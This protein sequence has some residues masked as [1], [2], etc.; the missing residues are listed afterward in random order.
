MHVQCTYVCIHMHIH[1]HVY[2]F[3]MYLSW[4]SSPVGW[5]EGEVE[6]FGDT[7]S[8]RLDSINIPV[9]RD[10]SNVESS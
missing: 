1:V 2:Q 3:I 8:P 10:Y 7:I 4:F 9:H 6:R 5:E